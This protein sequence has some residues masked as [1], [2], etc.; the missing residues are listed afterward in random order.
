MESLGFFPSPL[1]LLSNDSLIRTS[2]QASSSQMAQTVARHNR[3]Q[4]KNRQKIATFFQRLEAAD[5]KRND[6]AK[7]I[8]FI[9]QREKLDRLKRELADARRTNSRDDAR[10]KALKEEVKRQK[11]EVQAAYVEGPQGLS[12]AELKEKRREQ[13][14]AASIEGLHTMLGARVLSAASGI[15]GPEIASAGAKVAAHQ[16][17]GYGPQS[18][19]SGLLRIVT[20]VPQIRI[21]KGGKPKMPANLAATSNFKDN[22]KGMEAASAGLQAARE[23]LHRAYDAA[24]EDPSDVNLEALKD[25]L[26]KLAE[27]SGHLA[28]FDRIYDNLCIL[29]EKEFRGKKASAVVSVVAGMASAGALAIDQTGI[30]S[31]V[32]HKLLCLAGLLLQGPAS[33]FDFMDGNVDYPQ[34]MSAKMIDLSLLIKPESRHKSLDALQDEDIDTAIAAKLYDEQPQQMRG[35][36]R[37]IYIHKMG[38][39]NEKLMKLERKSASGL[40]GSD[41]DAWQLHMHTLQWAK[42]DLEE[43]KNQIVLFEQHQADGIDPDGLI[44][45]AIVD[46]LYFCK[47]GISAGVFNKVGEFWAQ[48]NQRISNNFNPMASLGLVSVVLDGMTL[49]VGPHFTH[50]G[51]HSFQ[52]HEPH[53]THDGAHSFQGHGYHNPAAE[54]ATTA[55]FAA[56]GVAAINSGVTVGPARFNKTVHD[57]KTLAS[58]AYISKGKGIHGEERRAQLEEA[59]RNGILSKGKKR[60]LEKALSLIE[61]S[62]EP[63]VPQPPLDKLVRAEE[64]WRKFEKLKSQVNEMVGEIN[65]HWVIHARDA[66][67]NPLRG[68]DGKPIVIDL[69][70]TAACHRQYMPALERW[71]VPLKG[72]PRSIIKSMTFWR[73][74][75]QA[76]KEREK[77]R[78]IVDGENFADP[79]FQQLVQKAEQ[80]LQLPREEGRAAPED[81][82]AVQERQSSEEGLVALGNASTTLEDAAV[83]PEIRSAGNQQSGLA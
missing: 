45:K 47:K 17:L 83:V 50:D 7:T 36:I 73:D 43:L 21:N 72:I 62:S 75:I 8:N 18:V 58:P 28:G 6:P 40:T 19:F 3:K 25:Q 12:A 46:P 4:E 10:I 54:H 37:A 48:A 82:I 60:K 38:N 79:E 71:L 33:P 67:G 2:P 68:H 15:S 76:K 66:N 39:L 53:D 56:S 20:E 74:V 35:V 44:G 69:R 64:R 59:L 27:A 49:G 42:H 23:S 41:R 63:G 51:V 13:W 16:G 55:A 61:A 24:A 80:L 81:G 78:R 5:N 31:V 1:A 9:L 30:A 14:K 70:S 22:R 29:L 77:C 57:R 26:R 32:G 11:A 52:G 34:K 65:E